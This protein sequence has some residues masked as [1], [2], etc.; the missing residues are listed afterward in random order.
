[1]K[2]A[3][4]KKQLYIEYTGSIGSIQN[5]CIIHICLKNNWVCICWG[6]RV[7]TEG[8]HGIP[9]YRSE[10]MGSD[11]ESVQLQNFIE[12][13]MAIMLIDRRGGFIKQGD[14]RC[15]NCFK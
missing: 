3:I 13:G 11:V 5:A 15:D 12:F 9:N 2:N 7:P 4:I 14:L 1:M 8:P 10:E 6:S